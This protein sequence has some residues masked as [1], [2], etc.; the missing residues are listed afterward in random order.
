MRRNA[1][2]VPQ[3]IDAAEKLL[4][5]GFV[6]PRINQPVGL[7]AA[8]G[9]IPFIGEVADFFYRSNSRKLKMVRR[10]VD[11]HHPGSRIIDA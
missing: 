3:R 1:W 10:H 5:R 9:A 6:I 4:A 8:R 11:R 7:D 2:A